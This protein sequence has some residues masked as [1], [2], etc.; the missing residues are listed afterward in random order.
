MHELYNSGIDYFKKENSNSYEIVKYLY[1][2]L[3]PANNPV[4]KIMT[5]KH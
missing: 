4:W 3:I 5:E 2:F 1:N